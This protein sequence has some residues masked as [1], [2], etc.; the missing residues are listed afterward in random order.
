MSR[1]RPIAAIVVVAFGTVASSAS[2]QMARHDEARPYGVPASQMRSAAERHAMARALL[3]SA[4]RSLFD[5]ESV[6]RAGDV[7][8]ANAKFAAARAMRAAVIADASLAPELASLDAALKSDAEAI[9]VGGTMLANAAIP[10]APSVTSTTVP[11]ASALTDDSFASPPPPAAATSSHVATMS[12]ARRAAL[13]SAAARNR[14]DLATSLDVTMPTP[15]L[16]PIG[17]RVLT[18]RTFESGTPLAP[19]GARKYARTFATS[20]TR[21]LYTEVSAGFIGEAT[22][23]SVELSCWTAR[24]DSVLLR[25][26]VQMSHESD[27]SIFLFAVGIG[28]GTP[29]TLEPGAYVTGCEHDGRLVLADSFT[30]TGHTAHSAY[31]AANANA[32][33][34][35]WTGAAA[36]YDTATRLD[37]TV[38]L[39]HYGYGVALQRLHQDSS[40]VDEYATAI[41]LAPNELQY[42]LQRAA[43]LRYLQRYDDAAAE[44]REII[45]I[46]STNVQRHGEL[47]DLLLESGNRV[48]ALAQY[49]IAAAKD[50]TEP[51][52]RISI[53]ELTRN[54]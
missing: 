8:R 23:P 13:D 45:R 5:G 37:S 32:D 50:P 3:D 10:P 25:Q 39:Y 4:R 18:V 19:F 40:A 38:A 7:A 34:D 53:L 17:A 48:G 22:T 16:E 35:D 30:V 21:Y 15:G 26:R 41:R 9:A 42:H 51:S 29:S 44:Y 52:Y 31:V 46:D 11:T 6:L 14:R 1:F 2:A 43:L 20:A 36:A 33:A 24:G 28:W 49:R 54:R 27:A 12:R 47:A